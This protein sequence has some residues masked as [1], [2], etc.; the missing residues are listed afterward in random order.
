M[1]RAA[2]PWRLHASESLHPGRVSLARQFLCSFHNRCTDHTRV[3]AKQASQAC[4]TTLF[5]YRTL[6]ITGQEVQSTSGVEEL[7]EADLGLVEVGAEYVGGEILSWSSR[8][9]VLSLEEAFL[10]GP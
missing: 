5:P 7:V 10:R 6:A 2:V 1:T 4:Y 8:P 9:V 3:S